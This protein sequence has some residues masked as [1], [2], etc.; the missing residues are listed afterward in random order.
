MKDR[1]IAGA[2]LAIPI[3]LATSIVLHS[4]ADHAIPVH[5]IVRP[6][7]VAVG[8]TL[9]IGAIAGVLIGFP[10]G[11]LLTTAALVGLLIHGEGPL[12]ASLTAFGII[13]VANV[14][15]RFPLPW[16][17]VTKPLL[18]VTGVLLALAIVR[19]A[20]TADRLI[21]DLRG[22]PPVG[23][24]QTQGPDIYLI[25][26]DGYPRSD[27]LDRVFDFDN[28]AFI[29]AL[30][31]LG[32]DHY[33]DSRSNYPSTTLSMASML[34][35]EEIEGVPLQQP[36]LRYAAWDAPMVQLARAH[37]YEFV[38]ISPGWDEVSLR[39]SDRYIDTGQ[40]GQFEQ[41][42]IERNSFGWF[43][44]MFDPGFFGEERRDRI[45][46]V[47]GAVAELAYEDRESPR[48]VWAHV[49]APHYPMVYGPGGS[50]REV[51][52]IDF[53]GYDPSA[54]NLVAD[55][56]ANLSALNDRVLATARAIATGGSVV[57][58]WS[59]HGSLTSLG[60]PEELL[61]NFIAARTPGQSGLLGAAP[62]PMQVMPLLL[63]AYFGT[64]LTVPSG[65]S[66]MFGD[67]R[68]ELQPTEP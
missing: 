54:P 62:S 1:R 48:L 59:D 68:Q 5:A 9:L 14:D 55:Y 43:A 17:A 57:V 46:D 13:A 25:L 36:D 24:A 49:P 33:Q 50:A 42:L 18:M 6:L 26:L 10:R 52:V 35:G 30:A 51:E 31:D 37:G 63:N 45:E 40:L 16:R 64:D 7:L 15:A 8:G 60:P 29:Q 41:S 3:A 23:T 21:N 27:T 47:L 12:Y 22:L 28:S 19:V 39:R 11:P 56:S 65:R 61:R 67:T 2:S 4:F 66:F 34:R 20:L 32:F 58:I 38:S 53:D 44:E